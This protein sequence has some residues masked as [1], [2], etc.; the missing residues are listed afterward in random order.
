MIKCEIDKF[1]NA[2]ITIDGER[3]KLCTELLII[4]S[5]LIVMDVLHARDKLMLITLL[6]KDSGVAK[7]VLNKL[8]ED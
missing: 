7:A 1:E 8:R 4:V 3:D 2:T 6:T 5:K